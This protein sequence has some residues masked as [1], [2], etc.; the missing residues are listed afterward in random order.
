MVARRREAVFPQRRRLSVLMATLT[1][2]N[3][4]LDIGRATPVVPL[5]A[6]D[7]PELSFWGGER[8]P[9]DREGV[10]ERRLRARATL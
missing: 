8:D 6:E 1:A 10:S 4:A 2:A 9:G 5:R 7:Y 3:G